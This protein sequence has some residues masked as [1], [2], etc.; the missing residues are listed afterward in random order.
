MRW[1]GRW[2]GLVAW[3]AGTAA[4][5]PTVE[6]LDACTTGAIA[7]LAAL[8]RQVIEARRS[9][10]AATPSCATWRHGV[11]RSPP[12]RKQPRCGRRRPASGW[13][14]TC[15]WRW[16]TP[17][18]CAPTA[19]GGRR[20]R[21]RCRP[22][23]VS[24]AGPQPGAAGADPRRPRR[25][26][27]WQGPPSRRPASRDRGGVVFSPRR[28]SVAPSTP[29]RPPSA[30]GCSTGPSRAARSSPGRVHAEGSAAGIRLRLRPDSGG[31]VVATVDGDLALPQLVIDV[32]PI[33]RASSMIAEGVRDTDLGAF[34]RA[35]RLLLVHPLVTRSHPD[36]DALSLVRRFAP[37]L[38][39]VPI[40]R[41]LPPRTRPD[42]RAPGQT[43]GRLDA[44]Q[45]IQPREKNASTAAATPTCAWR[46][47]PSAGRARR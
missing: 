16:P 24:A 13:H 47:A 1:Q 5:P 11:G 29:T 8:L 36:P 26:R 9:G 37:P 38:G 40:C 45:S 41:R 20:H 44:T 14:G 21:S 6:R 23:F 42:E 46:S 31:C 12:T 10:S 27:R 7:D 19:A 17:R 34:Q 28:G 35:A 2:S 39:N 22:S 30:A 18:P 43:C 3:F 32:E 4:E 33:G 25:P 15:R